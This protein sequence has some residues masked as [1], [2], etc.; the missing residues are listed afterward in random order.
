[1]WGHLESTIW[2][3][4]VSPPNCFPCRT[5]RQGSGMEQDKTGA[6]SRPNCFTCRTRRQGSGMR[7]GGRGF[8]TR[9]CSAFEA[10]AAVFGQ[11]ACPV[12]YLVDS[13]L[14]GGGVLRGSG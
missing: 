14:P 3:R 5:R 1:M 9:D 13:C 4:C 2:V 8:R 7:D 6:L 10:A 11:V 12:S